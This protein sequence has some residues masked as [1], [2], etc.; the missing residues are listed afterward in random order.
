MHIVSLSFEIA[1]VGQLTLQKSNIDTQKLPC[2]KE[3]TFLF[4]TIILGI[5]VSFQGCKLNLNFATLCERLWTLGFARRDYEVD[6]D[7]TFFPQETNLLQKK[8]AVMF[9]SF[10]WP[11]PIPWVGEKPTSSHMITSYSLR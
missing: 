4:Q 2:L 3:V 7:L 8:T 11:S 5:H 1:C 9:Y 10:S 6:V